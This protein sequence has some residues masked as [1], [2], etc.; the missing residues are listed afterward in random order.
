MKNS[1]EF[2]ELVL[3]AH[4]GGGTLTK[5]LV[6]DVILECCG[7]PVLNRLE[8]SAILDLPHGRLAFT[9]DSYVVKPLFF[10][11]GDIGKLAACGTLNDLVMQGA[12]PLYLSL[13]LIIEEGF[14]V[15]DLKRIMQSFAAVLKE[16]GV[17]L[18][19]GDTKVV[20]HGKAEGIYINTAG[21]GLRL[22][23]VEV[24]ANQAR[25]GDAILVTGTLGD[26]GFAVLSQRAGLRLQSALRSDT[27]PLWSLLQPVF[28]AAPDLRCLR[29]P[30]RGGLAAALCDLA[31]ASGVGMVVSENSLPLKSETRG[32][33]SLLGV[34]P[35]HAACEG[36]AVIVCPEARAGTVLH[37]LR[38][39]ELGRDAAV[40]G[41]VQAEPKGLV[42]LETAAGSR[43][44]ISPPSGEDLP[45]I[46]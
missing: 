32:I 42:L 5:Q 35:L 3:L 27:A 16:T 23:G 44:I 43:R 21:V 41:R 39:H 9:T 18:A 25:P 15:E 31:E 14:P 2:P 4:G 8:D 37:L 12:Q 6:H 38:A 24:H 34:D 28:Q 45:R 26:H 20:E 29:D 40:I 10:P 30:T 1:P 46:C 19:T 36:K 13:G 22:P 17:T 33:A 11:G 7:N